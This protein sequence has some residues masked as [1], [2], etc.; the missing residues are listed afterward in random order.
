VIS[1]ISASASGPLTTVW[2]APKDSAACRSRDSAVSTAM[3]R[4]APAIIAAR[5]TGPAP[6]TAIVSP[7]CT[8][9]FWTPVS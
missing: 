8:W 5:P 2:V 3:I 6:T 9:P 1:E 4:P 7:G